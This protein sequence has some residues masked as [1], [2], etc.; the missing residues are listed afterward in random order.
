MGQVSLPWSALAFGLPC[1]GVPLYS[2]VEVAWVFMIFLQQD[3][4]QWSDAIA[5]H[6]RERDPAWILKRFISPSKGLYSVRSRVLALLVPWRP[7]PAVGLCIKHTDTLNNIQLIYSIL[8]LIV[9]MF[10]P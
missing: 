4:L 7:G 8:H 3:E 6:K 5:Y 2:A 1:L 9:L 10:M